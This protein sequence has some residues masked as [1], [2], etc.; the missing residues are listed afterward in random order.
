[1]RIFLLRHGIADHPHWT[2]PDSQRPL[3]E[4]GI[5]SLRTYDKRLT[6]WG[7]EPGLILHS[8]YVRARQTAEIV[9]KGIEATSRLREDRRLAPGFSLQ[10][11][12]TILEEHGGESSLMLV[13]H[14]PDFEE[15]A[16]DL[17]GEASLEFGKGAICCI[18][19]I[20]MD[21]AHLT[22]T[23]RWFATRKMLAKQG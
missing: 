3:N 23:L 9:A 11:L 4:A 10:W 21:G 16:G 19:M 13:G 2:G 12:R 22:G 1:M 8:P 17:V 5:E 18:D 20:E 7:V 6:R 14:N 15:V